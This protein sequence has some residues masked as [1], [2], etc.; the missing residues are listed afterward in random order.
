M[1]RPGFRHL[2]KRRTRE[3]LTAARGNFA[4]AARILGCSRQNVAQIVNRDED[5]KALCE[6]LMEVNKDDWEDKLHKIGVEQSSPVAL[7]GLLNAHA[8][9]RGYARHATDIN[10]SGTVDH[11][12]HITSER[13]RGLDDDQLARLI[14]QRRRELPPDRRPPMITVHPQTED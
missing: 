8:R 13:F 3:A 10:I 12:L 11:R 2:A 1:S 9:D 7:L 14:E 4:N 5:L 6:E